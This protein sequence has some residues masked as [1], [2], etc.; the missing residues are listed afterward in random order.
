MTLIFQTKNFFVQNR[1]RDFKLIE[2]QIVGIGGVDGI[3]KSLFLKSLAGI[4]PRSFYAGQIELCDEQIGILS[5]SQRKRRGVHYISD[6]ISWLTNF[7]IHQNLQCHFGKIGK[8]DFAEF[9]NRLSEI[10]ELTKA[11]AN[12]TPALTSEEILFIYLKFLE[13]NRH[14][15]LILFDNPVANFSKKWQER[16]NHCLYNIKSKSCHILYALPAYLDAM[17]KLDVVFWLDEKDLTYKK[18]TDE[19]TKTVRV[20]ASQSN[21]EASVFFPAKNILAQNSKTMKIQLNRIEL[22]IRPGEILGVFYRGDSDDGPEM[23]SGFNVSILKAKRRQRSLFSRLRARENIAL[24]ILG[25][26]KNFRSF[27]RK[28]K[29]IGDYY[30]RLFRWPSGNFVSDLTK[31]EMTKLLLSK[32]LIKNPQILFFHHASRGL[33]LKDRKELYQWVRQLSDSGLGII[34]LSDEI[35]ELARL[36]HQVSILI[37]QSHRILNSN[38]LTDNKK[39]VE[40]ISSLKENGGS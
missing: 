12:P 31:M 13:W 25:D 8:K 22:N 35:E 5:A 3:G 40:A 30:G 1:R 19:E 24:S 10:P 28:S 20:Y 2:P 15:K 18:I 29:E 34:W 21:S 26:L 33:S 38:D 23:N 14:A 36:S 4:V 9:L 16:F 17:P 11:K 39:L 37:L 7:S 6:K 27:E 32:A